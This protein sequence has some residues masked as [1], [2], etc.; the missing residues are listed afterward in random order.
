MLPKLIR[1]TCTLVAS[2]L[3]GQAFA[4]K[5]LDLATSSVPFLRIAPDARAGGM[6]DAGVAT[7]PDV[8]STF[9]NI[10][11]LAFN[12]NKAGFSL[13]YNP[14]L[15]QLT[16][17][18]YL[19]AAS[20]YYKPDENQAI[21]VGL[22][23]FNLGTIQFTTDGVNNMGG[24]NPREWG[25]DIGYSRKLSEKLGLGLTARYIHSALLANAASAGSTFQTG[26]AF[27][28]DLGLYYDNRYEGDG[29]TLGAALTNMGTRISYT[30]DA[31]DK[32]FIPANLAIGA[33]WNKVVDEQH[34]ISFA[35]DLNK[36]LV[37]VVNQDEAGA[38]DEYRRKTVL[39]SWG[40]SFGDMPGQ[41][42]LSAGIEYWYNHLLAIR[43]G[44]YTE[45]RN[46]GDRRFLTTGIGVR[47][48][49]FGLNF[50]YLIPTGSGIYQNPLSN[51]LRF[52]LL[53][54]SL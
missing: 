40:N 23:Y 33:S 37:P 6:G 14:W 20:G 13:S 47:Y 22:R 25:L 50:S 49:Q 27:A 41:A 5:S 21:S 53:F 30:K 2:L 43:A 28:A 26:R 24:S 19:A 52:S 42:S 17:D 18:V 31:E 48:N 51:T 39:E 15:K 36:L 4:Q 16:S 38:L 29:F 11:K 45:A 54:T 1:T 34:A 10:G 32:D 8:N 9:W 12:E 46:K 7:L 35:L 44:Y 3:L